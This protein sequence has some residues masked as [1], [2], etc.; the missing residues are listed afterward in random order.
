MSCACQ[1]CD[2]SRDTAKLPYLK[3]VIRQALE[4]PKRVF[5]WLA[6]SMSK[7]RMALLNAKNY[8]SGDGKVNLTRSEIVFKNGS[9]IYFA[10]H[11]NPDKLRGLRLNGAFIEEGVNQKA[12]DIINICMF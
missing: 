6:P 11:H 4:K 2:H 12:Q 10:S 1:C 7:A 9:K 5:V 3:E 8:L